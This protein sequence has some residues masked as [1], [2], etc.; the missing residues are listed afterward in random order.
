MRRVVIFLLPFVALVA[1]VPWW[2]GSD[3]GSRLF[4]LPGWAVYSLAASAVFAVVLATLL[5]RYWDLSAGSDDDDG[6]GDS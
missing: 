3:D 5:G 6:F 4:G 1:T 2:F